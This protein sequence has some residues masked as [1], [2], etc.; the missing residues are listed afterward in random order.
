MKK[1]MMARIMVLALACAPP[2]AA[3][4]T[5]PDAEGCKDSP[6]LARLPATFIASC[7]MQDLQ[8]MPM[9]VAMQDSAPVYRPIEGAY[10]AWV[11]N[12][13]EGTSDLTVFRGLEAAL[14]QAGFSI[15]YEFPTQEITATKGTTWVFVSNS[16]SY[17][18][19]YIIVGQQ[20]LQQVAAASSATAADA[21]PVDSP[22][23]RGGTPRA[24][25]GRTY[26]TRQYWLSLNGVYSQRLKTVSA[27]AAVARAVQEITISVE[28]P[29]K[30][31]LSEWM[32]YML[33]SARIGNLKNGSIMVC[34]LMGNVVEVQDFL[35]GSITSI[36]FAALDGSSKAPVGFSINIHPERLQTKV[37]Q[38]ST[39]SGGNCPTEPVV[40]APLAAD[41]R[42]VLDPLNTSMVARISAFGVHKVIAPMPAGGV[43]QSTGATGPSS[44]VAVSNVE[45]TFAGAPDD[46]WLGEFN[47]QV[48]EG[49]G[50]SGLEGGI[51]LLGA[52]GA[53]LARIIL[54]GV[55]INA[56]SPDNGAWRAT[57]T[58]DRVAFVQ[59][60]GP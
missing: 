24:S 58:V 38:T 37:I 13:R 3:Q 17:Y 31:P 49:T 18:D 22:D 44:G 36:D 57:L 15:L 42:F 12:T 60:P 28:P 39:G 29:L 40:K 53:E 5:P 50:R 35:E 45:V 43:A 16:G 1:A 27:P 19:Q 59:Q 54:H 23:T 2:L 46:A 21:G 4:I 47:N 9:P 20:T 8:Q 51:V 34:D 56:L 41:F 6:I 25:T 30:T 32:S 7:E 11:Y 14:K 48:L 10:S 26:A 55:R 52:N 33:S